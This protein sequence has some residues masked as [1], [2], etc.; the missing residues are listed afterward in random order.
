MKAPSRERGL[1][2][3]ADVY[4]RRNRFLRAAWPQPGPILQRLKE[5]DVYILM[6]FYGLL[7]LTVYIF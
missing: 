1:Y 6:A 3:S 7:L 5:I 2:L 4:C